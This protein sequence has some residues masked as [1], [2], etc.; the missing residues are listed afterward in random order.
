MPTPVWQPGTLYPTGSLV[1][2]SSAPAPAIVPIPNPSFEEADHDED[3]TLDAGWSVVN[4]AAFQGTWSAQFLLAG[5]GY[6]TNDVT[7]AASPGLSVTASCMVQQGAAD[8]GDAG[9]RVEIVWL[10]SL[11]AQISVSQ[12]NDVNSGSGGAYAKSQVTAVAPAGT[13]KFQV[14][15]RAFSVGHAV[16]VDL[17][18]WSYSPGG[19]PAG[20]QFKAVQPILGTSD[21]SEPIWPTALGVQVVDNTVIWEA[22]DLDRVVWEAHPI[23]LSGQTEPTWPEEVGESVLDNTII[24]TAASL[25]ITDPNCPHSKVVTILQSKVYAGAGD[26][27]RFC[28]TNNP[29]DWSSDQDAGFLPTGLQRFGANDVAVL[30][31]YRGNLAVMNSQVYQLW[32]VDPD[33]TLMALLDTQPAIGSIHHLAAMQ[34]AGDLM[35][36]AAQ[37]VRSLS[38]TG[39]NQSLKSGDVGEPIDVLV[40]AAMAEAL[41]NGEPPIGLFSPG[42]G[43]YWI[44][45]NQPAATGEWVPIEDSGI[46]YV[47]FN[48]GGES[49]ATMDGSIIS[50]AAADPSDLSSWSLTIGESSFDQIQFRVTLVSPYSANGGEGGVGGPST[51]AWQDIGGS[52]NQQNDAVD[53]ANEWEPESFTGV[54]TSGTSLQYFQANGDEGGPASDAYGFLIEVWVPYEPPTTVQAIAFVYTLGKWSRYEFPFTIDYW[55]LR[56]D[57]LIIRSGDSVLQ[58]SRDSLVDTLWDNDADDWVEQPFDGTVWW[59]WLDLGTPGRDKQLWGFDIA[60]FGNGQ[61]SFGYNQADISVFTD[62]LEVPADTLY[63]GPIPYEVVAPS[64]SVKVVF[65]GG[66]S[67][68]AWSLSNLNLYFKD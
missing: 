60:G 45:F 21:A 36:L 40:Q 17:F 50:S 51:F 12:G 15:A 23:L 7:P 46:P 42:D 3:W 35:Y 24:W 13:A 1:V 61:V 43:Q 63:D 68:Q 4:A 34:V 25:Q 30:A 29:R 41:E 44:I 62:A 39:S 64:M 18:T 20:L 47:F 19:V 14:R 31:Q 52:E 5:S 28:G 26:I 37:G 48:S 32:Q 59:P 38:V 9:A 65:P 22:V 10:D 33:P 6:I 8:S 54:L 66:V 27:T 16:W 2:P 53:F 58:V 67:G 49:L 11:G 55:T 56:G 57:E